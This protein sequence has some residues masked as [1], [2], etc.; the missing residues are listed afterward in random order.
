MTDTQE[1]NRKRW[2]RDL[3]ACVQW[4]REKAEE[5][6]PL[7]LVGVSASTELEMQSD[8]HIL[9]KIFWFSVQEAALLVESF[10]TT[11]EEETDESTINS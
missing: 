8:E 2:V 3:W 5:T 7:D 11:E 6:A 4:H 9:H 1:E 10:A